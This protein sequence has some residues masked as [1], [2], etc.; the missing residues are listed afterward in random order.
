MKTAL[1]LGLSFSCFV[2]ADLLE[3][4]NAVYS[5]SGCQQTEPF[6]MSDK[7][8]FYFGTPKYY[9]E[10]GEDKNCILVLRVRPKKS[11]KVA[12]SHIKIRSSA[13]LPDKATAN[14]QA[15]SMS[16]LFKGPLREENSLILT[17]KE[18]DLIWSECGRPAN[19]KIHTRLK[20][21]EGSVQI[22]S[23]RVSLKTDP[24]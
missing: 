10:N 1:F 13:H 20:V 23:L 18:E 19:L 22:I 21:P 16:H 15:Q 12:I 8:A 4:E 11:I 6:L 2:F 14:F 3:F 17:T 7:H 24:C 9:V 5:G